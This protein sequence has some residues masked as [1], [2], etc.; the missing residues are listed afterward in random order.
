VTILPSLLDPIERR[1][2]G[3]ETK[4]ER[5]P[6][7]LRRRRRHAGRGR[8]GRRVREKQ[9]DLILFHPPPG[10]SRGISCPSMVLLGVMEML[11]LHFPPDH[12]PFSPD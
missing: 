10:R 7:G 4:M 1:S 3:K 12:L 9:Q 8:R 11:F 2:I 6:R 5:S